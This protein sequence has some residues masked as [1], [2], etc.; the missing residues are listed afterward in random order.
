MADFIKTI[1]TIDGP[2]K[3]D[4]NSLANLPALITEED[5]NNAI[6]AAL[7]NITNAEEVAV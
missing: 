7:A 4:Y 5:V 1:N 3:I 6:K 2:K